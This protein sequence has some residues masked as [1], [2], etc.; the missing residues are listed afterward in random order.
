MKA[1]TYIAFSGY[2][3]LFVTAA[4]AARVLLGW[5]ANIGG[6]MVPMWVSMVAIV[7]A[8]FLSYSSF[9]LQNKK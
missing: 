9:K 4:Q 3:F 1:K 5:E 2:V 8:G 6:W 7:I